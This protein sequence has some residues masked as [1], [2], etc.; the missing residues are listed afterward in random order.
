MKDP[1]P[2]FSLS[3]VPDDDV[4][5]DPVVLAL[6]LYSFILFKNWF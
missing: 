2:A 5:Y 1:V 3:S 6:S 4:E